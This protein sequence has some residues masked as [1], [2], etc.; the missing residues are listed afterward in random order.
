MRPLAYRAFA[1]AVG[2]NLDE[3]EL[4]PWFKRMEERLAIAPWP[5][6]PNANNDLLRRGCEK[7]GEDRVF[8]DIDTI[9]PG[10][11]FAEAVLVDHLR[12]LVRDVRV[13]GDEL[14]GQLA[15]RHGQGVGFDAF[16]ADVRQVADLH[17]EEGLGADLVAEPDADGLGNGDAGLHEIPWHLLLEPLKQPLAEP[18]APT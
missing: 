16:G 7:L 9:R 4:A 18:L 17:D 6:A 10:R 5:V 1:R 11:D 14:L 15:H 13:D 2:A 12:R 3:A 8:M